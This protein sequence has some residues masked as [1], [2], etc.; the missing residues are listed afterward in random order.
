MRKAGMVV[1]QVLERL[2]QMC[3]PGVSTREL[4]A[5]AGRMTRQAGAEPLFLGVP[6]RGGPFPGVICA[7]VNEQVVHGIPN[8]RPVRSGDIVSID[9]GCRLNGWCGDAARTFIVGEVPPKVDRLVNVTRRVLELAID[10]VRPGVLWS[11][12]A[13]AMQRMA[14]VEGFSVVR[15]FVGHGIGREMWEAPKL[16]NFVSMELLSRDILLH[17]GMVLAIEPMV[18]LG[19]AD[20]VVC[21]DGWTVVTKDGKPSA[22]FE[23]TVAVT[24]GGARVLTAAG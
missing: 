13:T 3:Q 4:D 2:A 5:E 6:G 7:S 12:V 24:A 11:T 20:V 8:D 17:E 10:L 1:G 16:P 21:G 18:N 14:E 23:H 9:Y 22:H 15:E 19:S